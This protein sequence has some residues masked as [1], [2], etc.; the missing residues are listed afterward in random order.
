MTKRLA[1]PS[2][3]ILFIINIKCFI[4][5]N[6]STYTIIALWPMDLGNLIIKLINRSRHLLFSIRSGFRTPYF[7]CLYDLAR[8]QV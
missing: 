3:I 7:A 4:F 5:V 8:E 2:A 6:L 1:V